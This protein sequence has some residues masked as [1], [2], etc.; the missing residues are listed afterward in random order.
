MVELISTVYNSRKD[1]L[2]FLITTHSPY[3]LTAFN[4]LLQAGFLAV[5]AT[6]EKMKKISHYVS[7]SRFLYPD[8]LTVYSFSDGY[9]R[10]I[11]DIEIGLINTNI[12]DEVSKELAI[13]FDQLL[14]IDP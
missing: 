5:D 1:S 8:E 12:I 11:L 6:E 4:N 7:K 2:Q 9:S 14:D 10:S 13:Q 3:V